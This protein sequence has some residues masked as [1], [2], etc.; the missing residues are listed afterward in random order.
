MDDP[1]LHSMYARAISQGLAS[2]RRRGSRWLHEQRG[3]LRW[4]LGALFAF[5]LA[6]GYY[7]HLQGRFSRLKTELHTIREKPQ[8]AGPL[9]IGGQE[10][11]VLERSPLSDGSMPEFLS[12]TLLPGRGMAVLQITASIPGRG[13][14]SLLDGASIE[15][16]ARLIPNAEADSQG[17]VT[18]RIS[19]PLELP[20][21]GSVPVPGH[22]GETKPTLEWRGH[23]IDLPLTGPH[24]VSSGGLLLRL[25]A[26]NI[27][28][29]VMPDGGSVSAEFD[30]R[31]FSAGWPSQTHVT[32][33][34]LLSN[35]A[36]DLRVTARN[37]GKEPEPIGI[38][39]AP[40]LVLPSGSRAAATLHLPADQQEQESDHQ[41]T[42]RLLD[43]AGSPLDFTSRAGKRLGSASIHS[44]FVHLK[45]GFLD[46]GPVLEL[47]DVESGTG[48]RMSAFAPQ[49]RAV[50]VDT[51]DQPATIR[52]GFQTNYDDP[53][54]RAWTTDDQSGI[55][56]LQ[57]GQTMQWRVRL[58]LFGL[59]SD[60]SAPL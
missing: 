24:N 7:A 40:R 53:F 21:A 4:I 48:L 9:I 15:D 58:E 26:D 12:A 16:A 50:R 20:W 39:W 56:L 59:S 31:D 8:S 13:V 36:F 44:T 43:V 17:D 52:L 51:G 25:T 46:N 45:T 22:D 27:E 5:G 38:G 14:V 57:P 32:V 47:K 49:I 19:S 23:A 6:F 37:M 60:A 28:R 30:A 18:R 55:Y 35:R 29:N 10:P 2:L 41:A 34:A 54:N 3:P 33:A 42:G 11:L 1:G